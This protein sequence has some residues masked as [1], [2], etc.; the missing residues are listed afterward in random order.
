MRGKPTSAV[1]SA[2]A[3][4]AAPPEPTLYHS[5]SES[6]PGDVTRPVMLAVLATPSDA[7]LSH[8]SGA[9]PGSGD[10]VVVLTD[11]AV[12]VDELV[13]VW[14]LGADALTDALAIVLLVMEPPPLLLLGEAEDDGLLVDEAPAGEPLADG[15]DD[16]L[17]VAEDPTL[18]TLAD[19]DALLEGE[20]ELVAEP[21]TAPAVPLE[22]GV[23]SPAALEDDDGWLPLL[24]D[25]DTL[26]DVDALVDADELA[27]TLALLLASPC[28]D[29]LPLAETVEDAP[30]P[31]PPLA[32]TDA[33][34]LPDTEDEDDTEALAVAPSD[35]TSAPED[36]D[37]LRAGDGDMP[38][39]AVDA[40]GVPETD[41]TLTDITDTDAEPDT[42]TDADG[43]PSCPA[44]GEDE[45]EAP[46]P[47]MDADAD[48][49]ACSTPAAEADA[50]WE[51]EAPPCTG[52]EVAEDDSTPAPPDG[53]AEMS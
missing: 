40:L 37:A 20:A 33:D 24:L 41:G 4:R 52:D 34:A 38:S 30:K 43:M 27:D 49:V 31:A 42:L 53:D 19:G 15:D 25:G 23:I 26:P 48:A 6:G 45:A 9:S 21:A 13:P 50:E 1:K 8:T 35:G 51:E 7:G 22:D 10:A 36:D 17:L 39:P 32:L 11:D 16:E 2:T 29:A 28:M 5:G 3:L 18:P 47:C 46:S 44:E 14:V 12:L